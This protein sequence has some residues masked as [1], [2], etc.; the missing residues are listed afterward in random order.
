M[1]PFLQGLWSAEPPP[2]GGSGFRLSWA[3]VPFASSICVHFQTVSRLR[4]R[5]PHAFL[6]WLWFGRERWARLAGP[7]PERRGPGEAGG[8][9]SGGIGGWWRV[10][11]GRQT[12]RACSRFPAAPYGRM[13]STSTGVGVGGPATAGGA[14]SGGILHSRPHPSP[15]FFDAHDDARTVAT[16]H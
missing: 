5:F 11:H 14:E 15:G 1:I 2:F 6:G 9:G 10:G 12:P 4:A 8:R 13:P 16:S 7:C 3:R